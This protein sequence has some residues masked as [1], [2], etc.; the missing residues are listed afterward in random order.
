VIRST[1]CR[2]LYELRATWGQTICRSFKYFNA[3]ATI[4]RIGF[5]NLF[6]AVI[7]GLTMFSNTQVDVTRCSMQMGPRHRPELWVSAMKRPLSRP[8]ILLW[9]SQP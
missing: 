1:F 7:P 8:T 9:R 2:K 3:M 4:E 6:R 5:Y